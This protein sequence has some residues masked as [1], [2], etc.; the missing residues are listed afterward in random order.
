MAASC[1]SVPSVRLDPGRNVVVDRLLGGLSLVL[2]LALG[3]R[4]DVRLVLI[5]RTA[6][7]AVPR[8]IRPAVFDLSAAVRTDA[9][10][11]Y[12]F[13]GLGLA[14]GT[15]VPVFAATADLLA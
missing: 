2:W 5:S 10:L 7:A 4:F 8:V 12:W 9:L 14:V 6:V 11:P 15:R 13:Q 1:V 3:D